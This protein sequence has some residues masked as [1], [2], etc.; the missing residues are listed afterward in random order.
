MTARAIA[1]WLKIEGCGDVT[2]GRCWRF[3]SQVFAGDADLVYLPSL[4]SP[5]WDPITATWD[6]RAQG[7]GAFSIGGLTA[8]LLGSADVLTRLYQLSPPTRYGTLNATITASAT[9]LTLRQR[10]DV[11][12]S[13]KAVTLGREVVR[14]DSRTVH[15][16]PL[17]TYSVT[18]GLYETR[19]VAHTVA[20]D[21]DGSAFPADTFPIKLLRTVTVGLTP[22]DGGDYGDEV[23]L[24]RGVLR[25]MELGGLGQWLA[26]TCDSAL[27]IVR[28]A[29][30]CGALWRG[31]Q[32]RRSEPLTD[33]G[34][35]VVE[36]SGLDPRALPSYKTGAGLWRV[37]ERVVLED[38]S[39]YTPAS[40]D[41]VGATVQ[42]TDGAAP[43]PLSEQ[44]SWDDAQGASEMWEVFTTNPS[45]PVLNNDAT[46]TQARL[47]ANPVALAR[48]LLT[49]TRSALYAS[50][51]DNG[52][53]DTGVAQLGCGVPADLLDTA[54]WDAAEDA[55]GPLCPSVWFGL[56]GEA[57]DALDTVQRVLGYAGWSLVTDA[58]GLLTLRRLVTAAATPTITLTG[59]HLAR[60]TYDRPRLEDP[61][62]S[63]V[64]TW[65]RTP[66]SVRTATY[67]DAA[68]SDLQ[69]GQGT[70]GELD[71]S[72]VDSEAEVTSQAIRTIKLFRWPAREVGCTILLTED[73]QALAVGDTALLSGLPVL[74][75]A[76]ARGASVL[77]QLLSVT[78]RWGD[79]ECDLVLLLVGL[80]QPN[81]RQI[82]PSALVASVAS[83]VVTLSANTYTPTL[84][85]GQT[86]DAYGW[87]VGDVVQISTRDGSTIRGT[88]TITAVTPATPSITLDAVPGG[89][90][91][92]DLIEPADYDDASA[93]QVAAWA[94]LADSNDA[95]GVGDDPAHEWT[96]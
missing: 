92:G 67:Q 15:A 6:P 1:F 65:G 87:A 12:L 75:G 58:A 41:D 29:K 3:A 31:R 84:A 45:S 71:L 48:Q 74:D 50:A 62:D 35:W 13:G 34:G 37:G 16:H 26:L 77:G 11:D 22:V 36:W 46:A 76:G 60:L 5:P 53:Y 20:P 47:S 70:Q 54:T 7:A 90:T 10:A 66:A 93:A 55:G 38:W 4:D 96:A 44:V 52:D 9:T 14:L 23:V 51:G 18:R 86:N 69:L 85:P 27:E 68:A 91:A 21:R 19:A 73:A 17:H 32:S 79:G 59:Q 88:A 57:L 8:R 42:V 49:S 39:A 28:G 63:V 25:G 61:L 2:S 64:A 94:Y 72:G 83:L 24:G 89:T 30:L 40:G 33:A 78:H 56:D 95:L 80:L 82:A 81:A 43:G